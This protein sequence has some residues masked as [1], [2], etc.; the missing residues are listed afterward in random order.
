MLS[1]VTGGSGSGKSAFAEQLL[2]G[3]SGA[4]RR[5]YLAVME[6]VDEEGRK[7][8]GRHQRLRQGKGFLTIEQPRRIE[9]AAE[10][11]KPGRNAVL[12][13]CMSNLTAN[14]MFG[15]RQL[16]AEETAGRILHS[17]NILQERAED[18]IIVTNNVFE[19]GIQYDAGTMEYLKALAEINREL[20][21]RADAVWEVIA[22][23]PVI[24]KERENR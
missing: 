24:R 20:A 22:G 1:L 15:S 5:Y 18:L 8:A 17:V 4:D 6:I 9:Q 14:E 11:M 2:S 7:K 10:V 23:I 19:D 3:C 21:E 13:E 12:L 16:T